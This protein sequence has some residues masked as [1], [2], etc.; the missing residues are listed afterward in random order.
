[1]RRL[2]KNTVK[3]HC[4]IV[5]RGQYILKEKQY[6]PKTVSKEELFISSNHETKCILQKQNISHWLLKGLV[7]QYN[8]LAFRICC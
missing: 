8:N 6:R 7:I 4:K 5:D 2:Q 3:I 1:M